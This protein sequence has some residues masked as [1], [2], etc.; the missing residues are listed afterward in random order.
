MENK[1][2]SKFSLGLIFGVISGAIAGLLLAP[3]TGK[4]IRKDLS[5]AAT[6]IRS[7]LDETDVKTVVSDI[8]DDLSE[9]SLDIFNEAMDTLSTKLSEIS[10]KWQT[11]DKEKYTG[12][13]KEVVDKVKDTHQMPEKTL[14]KLRKFLENDFE[15]LSKPKNTKQSIKKTAKK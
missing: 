4:K 6:E 7:R 13:V 15:K 14:L 1:K 10:D 11:I 12:V 2:S 5:K 8:F 9:K 3:K